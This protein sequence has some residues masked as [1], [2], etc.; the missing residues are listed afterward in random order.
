MKDGVAAIPYMGFT[1]GNHRRP[2]GAPGRSQEVLSCGSPLQ[3]GFL[4]I[5]YCHCNFVLG[6]RVQGLGF[7]WGL[8]FA[9]A[10]FKPDVGWWRGASGRGMCCCP[11]VTSHHAKNRE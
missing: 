10:W 6:L 11:Q 3:G 8:G 7:N 2:Q 9:Q 5:P 4:R 1:L